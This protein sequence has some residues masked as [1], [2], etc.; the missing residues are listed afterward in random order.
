MGKPFKVGDQVSVRKANNAV[1]NFVAAQVTAVYS[2]AIPF[3]KTGW[4]AEKNILFFY[5]FGLFLCF[6]QKYKYD[7]VYEDGSVE[8]KV[9]QKN[10]RAEPLLA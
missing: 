1:G 3:R 2:G 5:M 4:F 9:S 8:R 10:V 6:P 7:V